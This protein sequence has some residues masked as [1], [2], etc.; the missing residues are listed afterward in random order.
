MLVEWL[1]GVCN[2]ILFSD[3]VVLFC[4]EYFDKFGLLMRLIRLIKKMIIVI[5][6]EKKMIFYYV[7]GKGL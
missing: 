7:E 6:K 5:R 3:N 2:D 4:S 1:I